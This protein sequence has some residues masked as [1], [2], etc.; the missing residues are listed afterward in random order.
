MGLLVRGLT[1]V[2]SG[3]ETLLHRA[4]HWVVHYTAVCVSPMN[5]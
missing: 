1:D 2:A 4:I 5:C 3:G